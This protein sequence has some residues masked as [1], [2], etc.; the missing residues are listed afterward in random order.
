[1]NF[2]LEHKWVIL[3]GLEVLAW[4][5]TFFVF[6][7]RYAMKSSFWFKAAAILLAITGV[8]PQ[9]TMGIISFAV[10][11]KLDIYTFVIVLLLLYGF[12]FGKKQVEK[13]D[14]WMQRI[15][16]NKGNDVDKQKK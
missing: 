4:L 8:F 2:L 14:V 15:F 9:I 3:A 13:L 7:A 5:S 12:T 11:G 6:Y 1:M 10:S 16:L